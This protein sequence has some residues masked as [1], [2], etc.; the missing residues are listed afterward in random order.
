MTDGVTDSWVRALG[1]AQL[2]AT[3]RPGSGRLTDELT[4]A[5]CWVVRPAA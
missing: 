3:L 4:D 5:P 1:R 2:L